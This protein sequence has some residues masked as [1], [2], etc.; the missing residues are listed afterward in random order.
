MIIGR[1]R[2]T[3]SSTATQLDFVQDSILYLTKF[4]LT[5]EVERRSVSAT[6][7][8]FFV[9]F[10]AITSVSVGMVPVSHLYVRVL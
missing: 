8:V 9:A 6:C 1:Q 5:S 2:V 7:F 3:L 4:H 10:G